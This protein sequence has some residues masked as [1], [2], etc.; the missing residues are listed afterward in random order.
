MC[1]V[2]VYVCVCGLSEDKICSLPRVL[3]VTLPPTHINY[4]LSSVGF[5][6]ARV[7]LLC[8]LS[9]RSN[10]LSS[11]GDDSYDIFRR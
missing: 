2:C 4:R 5:N 8:T 10:D 1:C 7:L 6:G 9:F 11:D 3:F